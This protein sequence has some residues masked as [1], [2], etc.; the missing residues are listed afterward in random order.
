MSLT[1]MCP[2]CFGCSVASA[3][4]YKVMPHR[5]GLIGAICLGARESG[6]P[7]PLLHANAVP[8]RSLIS[9]ARP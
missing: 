8:P 5:I 6:L 4:E 9:V 3:P 7:V 2:S 1:T